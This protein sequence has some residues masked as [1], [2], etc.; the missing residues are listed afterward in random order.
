MN[1]KG[2]SADSFIGNHG[3]AVQPAAGFEKNVIG[4]P[5]VIV[6]TRKRPELSQ[7]PRKRVH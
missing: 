1:R 2:R 7:P 5:V 4:G 6:D 3:D